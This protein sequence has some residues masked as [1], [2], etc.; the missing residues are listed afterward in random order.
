[1]F[2]NRK[3]WLYQYRTD[4]KLSTSLEIVFL[5]SSTGNA[6]QFFLNSLASKADPASRQTIHC[7]RIKRSSRNLPMPSLNLCIT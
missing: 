7:T 4:Q 2:M 6:V 5:Q 1:M 3:V